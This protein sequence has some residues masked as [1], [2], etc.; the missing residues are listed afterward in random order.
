MRLWS[1]GGSDRIAWTNVTSLWD[2]V[3]VPPS[4]SN[5][6]IDNGVGGALI[7]ELRPTHLTYDFCQVRAIPPAQT[8]PVAVII[9]TSRLCTSSTFS[10]TEFEP[11][12]LPMW[13]LL[14]LENATPSGYCEKW[15]RLDNICHERVG[16]AET[17]P[18]AHIALGWIVCYRCRIT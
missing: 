12:A 7:L 10:G 9:S 14:D 1:H 16:E 17:G 4:D 11:Q 18:V 5:M 3:C 2:P 8:L 15:R 13:G 6:M